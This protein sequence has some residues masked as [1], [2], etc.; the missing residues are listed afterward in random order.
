MMRRSLVTLMTLLAL[1]AWAGA[2]NP[3]APLAAEDQVKLFK[4]NRLLIEGLVT[5]SITLAGKDRPLDRA[6]ECRKTAAILAG[7]LGRAA[8]DQD[9]D[10]V[11]ELAGLL[12]E[13]VREGLVPNLNQAQTEITAGDPQEARLKSVREGTS[14][15]LDE[16]PGKIPTEGKV[17]TNQKVKEAIEAILALKA[18]LKK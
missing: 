2:Q 14:R 3:A 11:L 12:K 7:S 8:E 6:D 13:V 5:Q 4:S 15:D 10:R 1:A 9:P 18:G 17:A 16:L